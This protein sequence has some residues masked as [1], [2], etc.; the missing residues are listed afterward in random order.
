ML[1]STMTIKHDLLSARSTIFR[2]KHF[3]LLYKKKK[4]I[5]LINMLLAKY[6][7]KTI[8]ILKKVYGGV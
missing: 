1:S 2:G 5:A 6:E 8:V 3:H 4:K 7:N